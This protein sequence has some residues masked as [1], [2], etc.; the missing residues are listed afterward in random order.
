MAKRRRNSRGELTAIWPHFDL[1]RSKEARGDLSLLADNPVSASLPP[2]STHFD[3]FHAMAKAASRPIRIK[4]L[5]ASLKDSAAP[6]GRTVFG[7]IGNEIEK[8][9]ANYPSLRWWMEEKGLVVGDAR[10]GLDQISRFDRIAGALVAEHWNAGRLKKESLVQI[11]EEL[12]RE[13]F[14]LRDNLQ[15]AQWKLIAN[16]HQKIRRQAIRSFSDGVKDRRFAG[17]VRRRL[18]V[19]CDRYEKALEPAEPIEPGF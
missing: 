14:Q 17:A 2:G 4:S 9:M 12:D 8:I 10:N 11:A 6:R 19:A 7:H 3:L 16:H 5:H 13:G 18:Y 1:K 15:P